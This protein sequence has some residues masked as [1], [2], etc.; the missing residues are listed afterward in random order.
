MND[1]YLINQATF[2]RYEDISINVKPERLNV[3][4]KKSTGFG[5]ETIFRPCLVL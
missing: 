1:I 4:I 3:F 2:Q 5:F